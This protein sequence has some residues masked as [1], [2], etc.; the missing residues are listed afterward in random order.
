MHFKYPEQQ[1][2]G[3]KL[4]EKL[5]FCHYFRISA[6]ANLAGLSKLHSTC[7]ELQFEDFFR[8]SKYFLFFGLPPK[9][10]GF[11]LKGIKWIFRIASFVARELF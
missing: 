2:E 1:F 4:S 8:K 7:T 5:E 10:F 6:K 11:W 9:I 3:K